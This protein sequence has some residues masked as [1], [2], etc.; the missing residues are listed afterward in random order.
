MKHPKR[1]LRKWP[2]RQNTFEVWPVSKLA[3]YLA[4]DLKTIE[5]PDR[6]QSW[7][8]YPEL[9]DVYPPADCAYMRDT[10]WVAV[11]QESIRFWKT[12]GHDLP[13]WRAEPLLEAIDEFSATSLTDNNREALKSLF[14]DNIAV[15]DRSKSIDQGRHR[16]AA[17]EEAGAKEVI[18]SVSGRAS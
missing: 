3:E 5:N 2:D 14:T 15:N 4:N 1:G 11:A 10:D 8:A 13:E 9:R 7:Y 16:V 12:V 18:V 6:M 17:L